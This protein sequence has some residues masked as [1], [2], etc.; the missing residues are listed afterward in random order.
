MAA[1]GEAINKSLQNLIPQRCHGKGRL[2]K[3][4][5]EPV[6]SG[7]SGLN[8]SDGCRPP[9]PI[10]CLESTPSEAPNGRRFCL[11]DLCHVLCRFSQKPTQVRNKKAVIPWP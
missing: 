7:M 9:Q 1:R 8:N 10:W 2:T 5:R 3:P 11:V 4:L 6:E